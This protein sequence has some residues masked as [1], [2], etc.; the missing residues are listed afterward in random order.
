MADNHD[1]HE[2]DI[3][4]LVSW[5]FIANPEQYDLLRAIA[6]KSMIWLIDNEDPIPYS[7]P[8]YDPNEFYDSTGGKTLLSRFIAALDVQETGR[9]E[10]EE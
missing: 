8:E 2:H 7:F 6:R 3:E 9:I 1:N 5:L 4:V 10:Y